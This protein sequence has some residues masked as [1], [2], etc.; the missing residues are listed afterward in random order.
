M[1]I[2]GLT[3]LRF[4][5]LP[6]KFGYIVLYPYSSGNNRVLVYT[7]DIDSNRDITSSA[8]TLYKY[9]YLVSMEYEPSGT[10]LTSNN[11]SEY[12]SFDNSWQITTDRSDSNLYNAKELV[13]IFKNT[14]Y[15]MTQ[16]YYNFSC[17]LQG[18]TSAT[19]GSSFI[20]ESFRL[21]DTTNP[22]SSWKYDWSYD[23]SSIEISYWDVECSCVLLYKT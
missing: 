15:G 4:M 20:G 11:Y 23:G 8:F 17:D 3:V 5:S 16:Q 1:T 12:I 19:L 2:D 22:P 21:P 14:S 18:N 10:F 6:N 13:I 9:Y 7:V